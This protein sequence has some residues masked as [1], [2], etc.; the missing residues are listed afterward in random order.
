MRKARPIEDLNT[1]R[2]DGTWAY[3][4]YTLEEAVKKAV[5]IGTR[6]AWEWLKAWHAGDISSHDPQP[7][8]W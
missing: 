5:E 4:G 8:A 3:A 7:E 6:G 1:Q 2:A